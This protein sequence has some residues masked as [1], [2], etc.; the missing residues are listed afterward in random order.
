M[1]RSSINL[2][3]SFSPFYA[4]FLQSFL[5]TLLYA[6]YSKRLLCAKYWI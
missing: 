6:V 2:K 1:M 4:V 5:S 3:K